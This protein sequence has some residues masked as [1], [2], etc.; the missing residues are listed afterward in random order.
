MALLQY[1]ELHTAAMP[2]TSAAATLLLVHQCWEP[3]QPHFVRRTVINH[4]KA[5]LQQLSQ[6]P[7]TSL[8]GPTCPGS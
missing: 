8:A 4:R 6:H 2:Q 7:L 1:A 3:V 5:L